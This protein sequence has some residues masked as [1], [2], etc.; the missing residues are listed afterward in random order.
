MEDK[1]YLL[2]DVL[3]EFIADESWGEDAAQRAQIA[4]GIIYCLFS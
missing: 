1:E 4:Y 2:T 3:A